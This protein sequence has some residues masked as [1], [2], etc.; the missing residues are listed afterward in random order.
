MKR[1]FKLVGTAFPFVVIGCSI[2]GVLWLAL[3]NGMDVP[4]LVGQGMVNFHK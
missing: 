2:A 4:F 1:R 3:A